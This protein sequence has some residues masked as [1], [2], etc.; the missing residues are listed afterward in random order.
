[1]ENGNS[2]T[3]AD[4]IVA[5]A[6]LRIEAKADLKAALAELKA[7]TKVHRPPSV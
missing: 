6:E 4:L 7:E 3:K 1:M 5:L 2:L